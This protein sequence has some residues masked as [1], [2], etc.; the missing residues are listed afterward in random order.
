MPRRP[1]A[2][3]APPRRDRLS[4]WRA[5]LTM[6][7]PP[8]PATPGPA[9]KVLSVDIQVMPY[10]YIRAT[11]AR[12]SAADSVSV[13]VGDP[14]PGGARAQV[15]RPGPRWG[16]LGLAGAGAG[17][18][19]GAARGVG[20]DGLAR[21]VW[22]AGRGTRGAARAGGPEV[23]GPCGEGKGQQQPSCSSM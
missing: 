23:Q 16:G 22:G 6:G 21:R 3:P 10:A 8:A 9:P 2:G 11:G 15:R 5:L 20:E 18:P 14:W 7:R 17:G 12:Y 13:V 4:A 1:P 19:A